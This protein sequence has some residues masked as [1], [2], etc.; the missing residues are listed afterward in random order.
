MKEVTLEVHA[1][2]TSGKGVARKLRAA[3]RLPAV[4]YGQK[5]E[6]TPIEL[7]QHK[8]AATMR[9]AAGEKM[10][11]SLNVDGSTSDKKAIIKD[12]QRDPV[13]GKMLHIDFQHI[14]LTE[15]IKTEVP[16]KLI[17]TPTGVKDF[18]GIMTFNLRKVN[19]SCL[20]TDIPD[21]F[22][23]NVEEMKINDS[24]HISEL[25]AGKVE[26]LDDPE[27]TVVSVI[28]PTVIKEDVVEEGEEGVEGEEGAE[29]EA[30][31]GAEEES[32]EPEVISE[33]KAEERQAGKDKK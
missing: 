32:A 26:I 15:K 19:V 1:R 29:G 18:G 4:I 2:S 30:A 20:P 5:E 12:I 28:P 23:I 10:L 22:E 21:A 17:G 33:K 16:I 7:D 8:F 27:E 24:L 13:S 14:S 6:P 11:L 3:G 25:D 31:E 9:Q